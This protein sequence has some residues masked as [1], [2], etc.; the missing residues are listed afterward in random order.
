MCEI[1]FFQFRHANR[2][3]KTRTY[4]RFAHHTEARRLNRAGDFLSHKESVQTTRGFLPSATALTTSRPP[5][6]QSP[7]VKTFGRFVWPVSALRMT[8]PRL[9]SSSAGKSR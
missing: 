3:V 5:L 1:F 4:R 9:S 6:A 8:T 2:L 7:P